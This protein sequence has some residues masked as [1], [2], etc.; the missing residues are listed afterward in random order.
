VGST[1]GEKV[2]HIR[3]FRETLARPSDRPRCVD[4]KGYRTLSVKR[5]DK[6]AVA[7]LLA[8]VLAYPPTKLTF[9]PRR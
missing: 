4:D 8:K 2:D 9:R 1:A 3:G 5:Y 6:L 7:S